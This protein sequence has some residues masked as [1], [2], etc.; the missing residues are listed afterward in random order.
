MCG[1][2][3]IGKKLGNQWV[4]TAPEVNRLEKQGYKK[5]GRPKKKPL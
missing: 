1:D 4:L 3:E 2:G 5:S